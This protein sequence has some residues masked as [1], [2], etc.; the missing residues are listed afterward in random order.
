MQTIIRIVSRSFIALM[1]CISVGCASFQHHRLSETGRLPPPADASQAIRAVYQLKSGLDGGHGREESST[2]LL[3]E[4]EKTFVDALKESGYFASV[5][6]GNE[7][8]III[9]ADMI[10]YGDRTA[11]A[12]A[13]VVGGLSLTIIPVWVTDNYKLTAKVTSSQGKHAIYALDDALTTVIWLPMI[14]VTPFKSPSTEVHDLWKNM[15]RNLI[16]K[17][18][19]DGFLPP[20][21]KGQQTGRL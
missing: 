12:I 9:E 1:F 4:F 17:M 13:G 18:Q 11:A 8:S 2:L 19:Q 14:V 6:P 15:Y 3:R 10:N 20:A 7:G 21:K 16:L 5:L